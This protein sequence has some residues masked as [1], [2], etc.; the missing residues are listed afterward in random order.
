LIL[1]DKLVAQRL[2]AHPDFLL[3]LH[4]MLV[5]RE[6]ATEPALF[7]QVRPVKARVLPIAGVEV[8]RALR[9]GV[10]GDAGWWGNFEQCKPCAA[11]T[12][13]LES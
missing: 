7:L 13:S 3:R 11:S 1:E 6:V 8:R 2:Q 12:A 4:E 10:N 9:D 5:T